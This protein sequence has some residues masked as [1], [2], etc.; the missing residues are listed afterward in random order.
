M[1]SRRR[2][3]T[4]HVPGRLAKRNKV[5]YIEVSVSS[6]VARNQDILPMIASPGKREKS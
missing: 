4:D 5:Q 3:L 2:I 1:A 6:H